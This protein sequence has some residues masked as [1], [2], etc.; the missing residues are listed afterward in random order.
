MR[1]ALIALVLAYLKAHQQDPA[2]PCKVGRECMCG[3]CMEAKRIL[4]MTK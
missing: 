2:N 3:T 1:E 4:G